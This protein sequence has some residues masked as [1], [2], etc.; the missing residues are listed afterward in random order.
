MCDQITNKFGHV[1]DQWSFLNEN[2]QT[3]TYAEQVLPCAWND[4]RSVFK[5]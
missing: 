2:I 4:C 5:V 3:Q 1:G